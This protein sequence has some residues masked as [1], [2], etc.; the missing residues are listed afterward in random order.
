M[1]IQAP[2]SHMK[3]FLSPE[4]CKNKYLGWFTEEEGIPIQF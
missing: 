2:I 4:R 1:R 3:K